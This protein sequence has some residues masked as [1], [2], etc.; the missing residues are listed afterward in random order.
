MTLW[1][2][3]SRVSRMQHLHTRTRGRLKQ[4]PMRGR[5]WSFL[6]VVFLTQTLHIFCVQ[7]G[8]DAGIYWHILASHPPSVAGHYTQQAKWLMEPFSALLVLWSPMDSPRKGQ[9]CGALMFS[10]FP[11]TDGW[12]NRGGA[13]DLRRHSA[14]CEVTVMNLPHYAGGGGGGGSAAS[15]H[16]IIHMDEK[17]IG[18]TL[19]RLYVNFW[20]NSK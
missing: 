3:S 15:Y 10:L 4:L 17:W 19:G 7:L 6:C 20:W 13:G 16:L 5:W 12:A 1:G 8:W 14:D 2:F 9:W 11:W 18:Q